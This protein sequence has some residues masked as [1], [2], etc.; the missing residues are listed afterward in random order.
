MT[1]SK[2]DTHTDTEDPQENGSRSGYAAPKIL[3]TEKLTSR[4]VVCAKA[5]D[6]TCGSGPIQS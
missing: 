2:I 4:A 6:G 1:K 3:H 5:D